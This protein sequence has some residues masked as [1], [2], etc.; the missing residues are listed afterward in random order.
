MTVFV[1]LK[2]DFEIT[3]QINYDSSISIIGPNPVQILYF[4]LFRLGT[5]EKD[6]SYDFLF[7]CLEKETILSNALEMQ[8]F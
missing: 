5:S 2:W 4:D 8:D 1:L 7:T 3:E 6:L